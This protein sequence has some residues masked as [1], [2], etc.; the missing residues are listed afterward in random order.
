MPELYAALTDLL[1]P[2]AD[3]VEGLPRLPH[4]ERL[5]SRAERRPAERDWRRWALRRA[6]LTAP[7][8][9]LP[10][11]RTLAGRH[12]HAP[13]EAATWF[14]VTP[15][16]LV[17]GLTRLHFHPR[18]ALTLPPGGAAAL[19]ARFARDW[20]DPAL[21]L[22]EAGDHLLLRAE[23]RFEVATVDPAAY[24]GRDVG[25]ALPTG[26][27]AGRVERLMT[28]LQM[29]LH[30][31]PPASV[32]GPPVNALWLWGAGAT[33]L[34]GAAAW[35]ALDGRDAFL[36]AAAG[37]SPRAEA[38]LECWSLAA[39]AR[40]GHAFA[41]ADA[42]WFGALATALARGSLDGARV[43]AR[44]LE[45]VLRPGQRFRVWVRPRPWWEILG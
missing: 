38:R 32:E 41:A 18:G 25:E 39:L 4:A 31:A 30:G 5:L 12:G 10:V 23:G 1:A 16:H 45:F 40:E 8:G 37:G 29:W 44:G 17:A 3:D 43:H 21:A 13:G 35:P 42:L 34:A 22:V 33:P 2:D 26:A 15:V 28:E 36:E 7:P 20:A 24:A 14:V 11:A 6:G 9:D 27:D 19:A